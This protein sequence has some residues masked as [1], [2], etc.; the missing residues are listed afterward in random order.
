VVSRRPVGHRGM[1]PVSVTGHD[2]PAS[3]GTATASGA[4]PPS[5]PGVLAE[6]EPPPVLVTAASQLQQMV[7]QQVENDNPSGLRP[8]A[9]SASRSEARKQRQQL[10]L[11][12]G[13]P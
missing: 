3:A 1:P 9:A 7:M 5:G 8:T 12:R 2:I 11:T 4:G 10:R 13:L 6:R